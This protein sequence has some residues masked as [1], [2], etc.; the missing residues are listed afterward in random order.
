MKKEKLISY[1]DDFLR[2]NAFNNDSSKNWLQVDNEKKEIKKIWYSVDASTYIF[3]LAKKEN[4]DL[5]L[6]HHGIFWWHESLL[7]WIPYERIKKLISSDIALYACHLPL[8]THEKV[9]N[10]IWLLKWFINIFGIWNSDFSFDKDKKIHKWKDFIVEKFWAWEKENICYML[11][12]DKQVHISNLQTLYADTMQLQKKLYNFW[13][14]DYIKSIAFIS[15]WWWFLIKE[16]YDK[17]IDLFLTWEA[18][19][20]EILQA[21]ELWQSIMLA[22]HYETEKI[23]PKLLAYHLKE[24]F[25]LDVIFLDEKY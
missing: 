2:N 19:H 3:D 10:N 5:I 20:K 24:K 16:A 7:V 14:K 17:N 23:W 21:K 4:V 6:C 9:G 12:F 8:D 18:K 1:L 25:D 13:N 15:W 22:W 11:K